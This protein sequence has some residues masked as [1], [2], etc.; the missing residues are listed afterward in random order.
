MLQHLGLSQHVGVQSPMTRSAH[1][2]PLQSVG[3]GSFQWGML[4]AQ[5]GGEAVKHL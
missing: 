3:E 1:P 5:L 2:A 4:W